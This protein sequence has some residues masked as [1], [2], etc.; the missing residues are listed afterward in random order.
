MLLYSTTLSVRKSLT[1]EKFIDLILTWNRENSHEENIIPGMSWSGEDNIRFG[2]DKLWLEIQ[3]YK[4]EN[5]VA[6][7]YEKVA[8][9]GKIWD[10][11]YILNVG[12][13]KVSVQLNRSYSSD[14]LASDQAYSTPHFLTYLINGNYVIDD[15]DI[16]V[17]REPHYL[18]ETDASLLAKVIKGEKKYKLPVVYV[19]RTIENEIPI[20]IGFLASK[21]KGIAHVFVQDDIS[22]LNIFKEACDAKNEYLGAI[23]IY[24]PN[25]AFPRKRFMYRKGKDFADKTFESIVNQVSRYS[26]SKEIPPLYTYM[27]IKNALLKDRLDAQ[28]EERIAAENDSKKAKEE[29][30]IF[31]S[32]FDEDIDKYERRIAE[33]TKEV[34]RLQA[35]NQGY[36][37]KLSVIGEAPVIKFGAERDLYPEEIKEIIL[38]ILE[39]EYKKVKDGTRRHD[40][41]TDLLENNDY[42]RTVDERKREITRLLTGY[43]GMNGNL[44][45]GLRDLGFDIREGNHYVLT[46]CCDERYYTC[47]AK[48]PS[49]GRGNKNEIAE[50]INEMF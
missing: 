5:I 18:K 47:L 35:E 10:T 24:Y 28:R 8:S 6:V 37:A 32:S 29:M 31:C 9:D 2:N 40:L 36:R 49:D 33:L 39:E 45:S 38:S 41:I 17:L 42:K 11:D 12:E 21:L 19:S 25:S 34:D 4:N 15:T 13:S 44:R 26:I 22:S 3:E 30:E 48:T 50:I 27:G 23:G 1:K 20:D 43:K 46:Y 7:R 16:P 14:A